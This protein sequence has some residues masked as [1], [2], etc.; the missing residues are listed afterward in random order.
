MGR[1]WAIGRRT[2]EGNGLLEQGKG[3]I[4]AACRIM[5]C[6]EFNLDHAQ[7]ARGHSSLIHIVS[8]LA[9][10][11]VVF[12]R[13]KD[14]LLPQEPIFGKSPLTRDLLTFHRNHRT[15]STLEEIMT[16]SFSFEPL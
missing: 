14:G 5:H 16:F 4:K 7:A 13:V 1:S 11:T 2:R 6:G 12:V 3:Q 10:H 9:N 15:R 8:H